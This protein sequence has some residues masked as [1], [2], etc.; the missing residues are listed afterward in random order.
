MAP[1]RLQDKVCVVTGSSSGVG[2]GIALAYQ[3][4]GAHVVCVDL[5]PK[6]RDLVQS[7]T[8][9][10]TDDIIRQ[11]GGK[12][13]FVQADVTKGSDWE[14]VVAKAVEEYGRIDV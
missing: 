9:N 3:K 6:A 11:Q 4:E 8:G 2:R 14:N 13:I 7:E 5:T 12:A 1:G 10:N